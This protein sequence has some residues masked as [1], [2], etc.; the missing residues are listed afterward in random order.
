MT[1]AGKYCESGDILIRDIALPPME[2]G[3]ILA[4][5]ASGAYC[6]PM[7][8]NY[9]AALRPAIV[10]VKDGTARLARRRETYED[11]IRAELV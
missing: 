8:S 6:I 9:N 7:S 10:F 1:I 3:D 2:A 11:L 5:P 4:I